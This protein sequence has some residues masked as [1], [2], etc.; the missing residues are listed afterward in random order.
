MKANMY[1]NRILSLIF[2]VTITV[3]VLC[4][5]TKIV[6]RKEA[7]SRFSDF[8]T[9]DPDIL[10]LGS[11]HMINGVF[12]PQLWSDY[13]IVSYNCGVHGDYL[14]S[15]YW[16]M[17][18]MLDHSN[19]KLVVVDCY[20]VG[21]N[22]KLGSYA[23]MHTWMDKVPLS[24]NKI[25]AILDLTN[26]PN[27]KNSIQTSDFDNVT[28]PLDS[29]IPAEYIWDFI[30][31]HSRW[32]EL[33]SVDFNG[34]HFPYYGA[35]VR[36]DI[37][38]LKYNPPQNVVPSDINDVA[39]DYLCKI[40]N[41]CKSRNID[42]LLTYMP[43]ST[44]EIDIAHAL[45]VQQLAKENGINFISYLDNDFINY[46]TDFF[47]LGHLNYSG[48]QKVTKHLGKYIYTNYNIPDHRNDKNYKYM[49]EN[50]VEMVDSQMDA[51]SG[52]SSFEIMLEILSSDI[53]NSVIKINNCDII[54]DKTVI[55]FLNNM[56][57]NTNELPTVPC[58][59]IINEG[60]CSIESINSIPKEYTEE[61]FG[62]YSL[63]AIVTSKYT[64]RVVTVE[65]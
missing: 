36:M 1:V 17:M 13:G 35:E 58:V 12:P 52:S 38:P 33:E 50:Y 41:E 28:N 20:L 48:Q 15:T 31:Y 47:D 7:D 43:F 26:D 55:S 63:K 9:S 32:N 45:S 57:L 27:R 2:T 61:F 56:G 62:D 25:K 54:N 30:K 5:L 23:F 51:L 24:K 39:K 14:P 42:V 29:G 46:E 34:I 8:Y 11:S 6:E 40:I 37:T 53:F 19:P 64:D 18:N 3:V 10:F 65:L 60:K 44:D 16:V 59:L 21:S 22:R 4:A 49:T